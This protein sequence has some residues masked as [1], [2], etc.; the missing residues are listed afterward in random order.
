MLLKAQ[1]QKGEAETDFLVAGLSVT[2]T[3]DYDK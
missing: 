1:R 3:C 2:I